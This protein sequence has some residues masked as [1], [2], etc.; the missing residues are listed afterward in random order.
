ME[1]VPRIF[2]RMNIEDEHGLGMIGWIVMA[3]RYGSCYAFLCSVGNVVSRVDEK[4]Y[5]PLA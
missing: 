1:F 3:Y 4:I 5:F 2:S